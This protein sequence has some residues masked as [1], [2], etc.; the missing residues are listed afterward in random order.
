MLNDALAVSR[1][2]LVQVLVFW[3]ASL[4]LS[5]QVR[6]C[7]SDLNNA[8][9]SFSATAQPNEVTFRRHTLSSQVNSQIKLFSLPRQIVRVFILRM[10]C[11][12]HFLS[13]RKL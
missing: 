10:L 5:E 4:M 2:Q 9:M 3:L 12:T 6:D 13:C 7:F 11:S 8:S 1:S